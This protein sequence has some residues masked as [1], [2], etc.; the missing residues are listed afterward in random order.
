MMKKYLLMMIMTVMLVGG[1]LPL[2]ATGVAV[3]SESSF[4]AKMNAMEERMHLLRMVVKKL[5]KTFI[6]AKANHDF[7]EK[8]GMPKADIERLEA[9]FKSKMKHMIDGAIA[10]INAI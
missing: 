2:S 5:K 4:D 1:N 3:A 8:N 10:E 7:M 6:K 9:A